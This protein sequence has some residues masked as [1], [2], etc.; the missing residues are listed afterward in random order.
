MHTFAA[1]QITP[2]SKSRI[3]V[4]HLCRVQMYIDRCL[5]SNTRARNWLISVRVT[6]ARVSDEPTPVYFV[7][8]FLLPTGSQR[9]AGDDAIGTGTNPFHQQPQLQQP[10]SAG[11]TWS[12]RGR[13]S[14]RVVAGE[15][16]ANIGT[17]N[18][19]GRAMRTVLRQKG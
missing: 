17:Y 6:V 9:K 3:E 13:G 15:K 10:R 11:R 4:K 8:C 16:G 12:S 1:K 5:L 18:P 19:D 14:G 2:G 7:L